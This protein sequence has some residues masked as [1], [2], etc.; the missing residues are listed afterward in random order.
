MDYAANGVNF[1]ILRK[2]KYLYVVGGALFKS[3]PP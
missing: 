2:I 1:L 3:A